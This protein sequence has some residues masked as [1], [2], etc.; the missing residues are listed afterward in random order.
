VL[1]KIAEAETT[2][3]GGIILAETAQRKPTS[4]T[5]QPTSSRSGLRD[6]NPVCSPRVEKATRF[7]N[8]PSRFRA[9]EV[10]ACLFTTTTRA[11]HVAVPKPTPDKHTPFAIFRQAT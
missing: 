1:V 2:T 9:R 6:L 8:A 4:G 11:S 7:A 3:A 10:R 5:S